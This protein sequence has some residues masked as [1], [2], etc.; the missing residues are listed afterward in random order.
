[1]LGQIM[2]DEFRLGQLE[3]R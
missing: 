3:P 2:T 1:M